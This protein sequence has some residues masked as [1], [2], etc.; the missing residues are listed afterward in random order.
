[1]NIKILYIFNYS[2][3]LNIFTITKNAWN[4]LISNASKLRLYNIDNKEI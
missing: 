2:S 4:T 1:M 3:N